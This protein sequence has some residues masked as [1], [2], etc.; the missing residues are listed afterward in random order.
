[1]SSL[2]P[3]ERGFLWSINDVVYGNE[4]KNRKPVTAFIREVNNYPGLLDIIERIEGLINKRS[5]HASG[6]ILYND[7]PFETASFMRTPGGDLITSYDLHLAEAAGDTKYD[8]L[9]TEISDKIIKCFELLQKDNVVEKDFTIRQLYNK[10]IHPE[11]IDTTD[12]KLWEH[13][14]AGDVLDVFQFSTGVGLAIAK[15]L[16]PQNPMEMTAANAMMRLMSEKD[17]ESQQDRY[18]RIQKQGLHIFDKEMDKAGFTSEQKQLMHKHCDQYWGCCA[19]QEQMMELL[20]DVAGFTLGEANNARKIV[21]KK[22]MN[23]IPELRSQVYSRFE[24]ERVA[25]Y[26]W[27][28]AI[29]P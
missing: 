6:V 3:Q 26:F 7:D 5:S 22:L 13:L 8:F 15:K 12:K 4:E 18:I 24:D 29:A 11:I 20:M 9:V 14:A 27:E 2:V 10:Y 28:N 16:K 17:K 21:G 25:N 19:L 1:M 23:K